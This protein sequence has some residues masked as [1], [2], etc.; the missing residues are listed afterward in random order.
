[1]TKKISQSGLNTKENKKLR[2]K[3]CQRPGWFLG[4]IVTECLYCKKISAIMEKYF[5]KLVT[6]FKKKLSSS[7]KAKK[8]RGNENESSSNHGINK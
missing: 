7:K 4:E 1:M 3:K 2:E 5:E 6:A 8:M